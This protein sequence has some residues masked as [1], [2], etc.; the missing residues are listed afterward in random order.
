MV[1]KVLEIAKKF[2]AEGYKEKG[3]NDT[4]FGK[5]YGLNFNPWCAMY[6]SYCFNEAGVGHLVSASS[7]KGFASC[8]AGMKWFAKNGQLVPVGQAQAGDIVFFQFDTDAQPDHVGI[9]KANDKLLKTLYVY[10]GNTAGDKRGSQSNGDGVYVKKR[11]YGLVMA[12]ARP[13]WDAK[14]PKKTPAKKKP[15]AK[16]KAVAKNN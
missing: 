9:V 8:D 3:N 11:G 2:A 4:I 1:E 7:K 15:V 5:W 13:N 12:V 14:P 10:E 16:K 6:V